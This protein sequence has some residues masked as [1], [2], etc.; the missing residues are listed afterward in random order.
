MMTNERK[1]GKKELHGSYEETVA[2]AETLTEEER[3]RLAR[4][5]LLAD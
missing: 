5:V 1:N 4:K 2:R 3:M